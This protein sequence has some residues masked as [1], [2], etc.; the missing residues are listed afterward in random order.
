MLDMKRREFIT[1]LGSTAAPWPDRPRSPYCR[2]AGSNLEIFSSDGEQF[3]GLI[4]GA[5]GLDG[6]D[7][8]HEYLFGLGL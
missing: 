6:L 1:L 2:G 8:L 3:G 7:C 4:T 5:A